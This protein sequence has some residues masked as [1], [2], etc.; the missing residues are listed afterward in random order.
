MQNSSI[1]GEPCP[2]NVFGD[3]KHAAGSPASAAGCSATQ[4]AANC[5][6]RTSEARR[7]SC[8]DRNAANTPAGE[9]G[10]VAVVAVAVM[11]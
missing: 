6:D 5:I 1:A 9:S 3:W 8:S 11:Y 4:C 7:A 2:A 10:K